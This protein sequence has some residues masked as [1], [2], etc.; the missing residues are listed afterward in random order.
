STGMNDP[1]GSISGAT[2][3]QVSLTTTTGTALLLNNV[4]SSQLT[5]TGVTTSGG[6]GVALTGTNTSTTFNFT[7]VAISSGANAGFSATGG[8]TVNATGTTNTI[9]SGT[10]TALNVVNTN[11]GGSDLNFQ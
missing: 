10:R 5:F 4:T 7:G 2:V 3:D 9:T 8:G 6:A 1:A 11:I